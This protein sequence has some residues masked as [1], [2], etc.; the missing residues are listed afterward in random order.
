MTTGRVNPKMRLEDQ[1]ITGLGAAHYNLLEPSLIEASLKRGEG[2]LGKGGTMLVTTGKFT[3]RSPKDKHVVRT[4]SVEDSIWWENNAAMTPEGFDAL[5]ADILAHMQ[6]REYFV[7]DLHGGAD[8]AHQIRVRLVTEL[9]WHSLFIRHMLRRPDRDELD[10]FVPEF[11]IINSPTFQ[12]NPKKHNCRSETVI[13][14]NFDRKLILIGGTEYAGENKKSVFTLLNYL[15]PQKGVMPMHCSANHAPGNPVDAAV[16]FGGLVNGST[17]M[18]IRYSSAC[19]ERARRRCRPIRTGC[20]WA[21][22]NT[23]G[24]TV[25][26]ST[27]R[28]AATPRPSASAARPSPKSMQ[29]PKSSAP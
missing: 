1:G 13:A 3:G 15:L 18:Q 28:A 2:S 29:R 4:P 23:A 24:R 19:P 14:I 9:A 8:P 11:T 17:S 20:F 22:T 10:T 7:Q 6:G 26:P 25:E 5:Y 27:S 21:M 16:F 12:A